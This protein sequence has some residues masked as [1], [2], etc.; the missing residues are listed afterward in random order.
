MKPKPGVYPGVPF[1]EYVKW[2]ALNASALTH[3]SRSPASFK[4]AEDNQR[5]DTSAFIR[6]RYTHALALEPETVERDYCIDGPINE[7]TGKPYGRNT[8][9]F[10]E[11]EADNKGK[12]IVTR[13]EADEAQG[14]VEALK[15]HR[16]TGPLL[17]GKGERE[18]SVV[19]VCKVSG[20][21]CKARIDLKTEFGSAQAMIDIKSAKDASPH[22]FS[23]DAA[24]LHYP[25]KAAHYLAGARAHGMDRLVF[26][27]VAVEPTPPHMIG[28][29]Y[30]HPEDI[31]ELEA[32]RQLWVKRVAEC[33]KSGEWPDFTPTKA[34]RLDI[35]QWYGA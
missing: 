29:Y 28:V 31:N 11:W 3:I 12:Q 5:E 24:R 25:M 35:P 17:S 33:R 10:E 8:K 18:L 21:L 16:L 6:G 32:R 15:A 22:G 26:M 19:W 14:M 4:H 27:W 9:A 34:K 30:L 23:R 7:S 2:D 20:L 13:R 1:A